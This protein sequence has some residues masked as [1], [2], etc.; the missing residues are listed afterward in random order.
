LSVP[1]ERNLSLFNI[2]I[3]GFSFSEVQDIKKTGI[4]ENR[5]PGLDH[6]DQKTFRTPGGPPQLKL[7]KKKLLKNIDEKVS[8]DSI[9]FTGYTS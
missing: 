4:P 2:S 6:S 1:F 8:T 5:D 3:S 7:K 9:V